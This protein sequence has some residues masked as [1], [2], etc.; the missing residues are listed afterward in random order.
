[1][2]K[3]LLKIIA[4]LVLIILIL[5]VIVNVLIFLFAFL[6]IQT[7]KGFTGKTYVAQLNVSAL[8]TDAT[9]KNTFKVIYKKVKSLPLSAGND[10][11]ATN[12]S[13]VEYENPV[14]YTMNG[15]EFRTD[16]LC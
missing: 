6:W 11:T 14:T 10:L 13:K 9:G 8:E 2:V 16:Y 4:N 12:T 3:K 5:V 15:N 7:F 1:M